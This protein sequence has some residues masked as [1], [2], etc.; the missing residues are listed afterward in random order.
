MPKST[1]TPDR[2]RY[3]AWVSLLCVAG[4]L[5]VLVTRS[6]A[7]VIMGNLAWVGDADWRVSA[8][9]TYNSELPDPPGF[10]DEYAPQIESLSVTINDPT[11]K[12]VAQYQN[13]TNGTVDCWYLQFVFD[14]VSQQLADGSRLEFGEDPGFWFVGTING[15]HGF[16][17]VHD[18]YVGDW[19]DEDVTVFVVDQGNTLTV[20]IIPEPSGF[21][22]AGLGFMVVLMRRSV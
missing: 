9:F 1:G 2:V 11:G 20:T 3:H 15:S 14:P 8:D 17:L 4:L 21:L 10:N 5:L 18:N 7:T 6:G 22:L 16:S 19:S 13:V 12:I